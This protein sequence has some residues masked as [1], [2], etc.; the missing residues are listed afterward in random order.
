[1]WALRAVWQKAHR[2]ERN[3]P[4]YGAGISHV[5][6]VKHQATVV[7]VHLMHILF[8]NF[9]DV[10]GDKNVHLVA[11]FLQPQSGLGGDGLGDGVEEAPT[12]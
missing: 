4:S 6:V 10:G 12:F 9:G 7:R 2:R 11:Q 8:R 1:M 5:G 3:A